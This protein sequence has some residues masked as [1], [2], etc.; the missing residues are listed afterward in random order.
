MPASTAGNDVVRHGKP[1]KLFPITDIE[2]FRLAFDDILARQSAEHPCDGFARHA[3]TARNQRLIWRR[4]DYEN[5]QLRRVG[6]R[7]AEQFEAYALTPAE[8]RELGDPVD[9]GAHLRRQPVNHQPIEFGRIF[10]Q[11]EEKIGIQYR[12]PARRTGHNGRAARLGVNRGNFAEQV[13]RFQRR[14]AFSPCRIT[15]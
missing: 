12:Q 4:I 7:H 15:V 9:A 14:I 3:D 1:L 10:Q 8:Q 6:A 5:M 13:P 2:G 11:F